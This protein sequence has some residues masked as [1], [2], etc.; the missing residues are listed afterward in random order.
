MHQLFMEGIVATEVA[1]GHC[2]TWVFL[3]NKQEPKNK[4][5]K[6]PE[7]TPKHDAEGKW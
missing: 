7:K 1:F 2:V 4:N 6:T 5:P 3:K